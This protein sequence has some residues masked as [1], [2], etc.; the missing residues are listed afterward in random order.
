M[1]LP[2]IVIPQIKQT[3]I[4]L[5]LQHPNLTDLQVAQII[6]KRFAIPIARMTIN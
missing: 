6:S 4:E 3:V 1:G 2:T 5:T